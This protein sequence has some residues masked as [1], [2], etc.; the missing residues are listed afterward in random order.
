MA[1]AVNSEALELLM[2]YTTFHI[3]V[4]IT[5]ATAVIGADA[6]KNIGHWSL[7]FVALPCFTVAGLAGGVIA[8]SVAEFGLFQQTQ[9]FADIPLGF[10]GIP[11]AS[12]RVWATI[13]HTS[14]W[15]GVAVPALTFFL[16]GAKP[17]KGAMKNQQHVARA[18]NPP[19]IA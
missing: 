14:F 8:S 17:F 1:A 11:I 16:C 10:W 2:T 3:G 18:A 9:K 15:V 5:L 6:L 19:P 7:R 13:E 12:Y 4:Y